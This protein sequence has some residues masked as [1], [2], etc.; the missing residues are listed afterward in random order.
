MVSTRAANLPP[1]YLGQAATRCFPALTN[2][3]SF[4]RGMGRSVHIARDRLVNPTVVYGNFYMT[5]ASEHAPLGTGTLKVAL[6]YP[7][8]TFTLANECVAAGNAAVAFPVGNTSLTFAVTV[9]KG[10]R[11]WL[12]SYQVN[13]AGILWTQVAGGN[14][15]YGAPADEGFEIGT[16]DNDKTVNGV[17]AY[18]NGIAFFPLVIATLK[19]TPGIL[20]LG[21]SREAGGVGGVI[22]AT[23]DVGPAARIVGP[24]AGYTQFAMSATLQSGWNAGSHAWLL[25]LV[26]A[27][28][29]THMLNCYGANDIGNGDSAATVVAARAGCAASAKGVKADLIVI[30]NT[31]YPYLASSD[32]FV[33]KVNQTAGSNQLRILAL[34]DAIRSGIAGE[35]AVWDEADGI[36]P[37]R[38]G[39][40]PVSR[41]PSLAA[42]TPASVTGA[43]SGTTLTVTMIAV[44]SLGAGDYL[45]DAGGNIA[46][47]TWIVEQLTGTTGGT[48]TYRVSKSHSGFPYHNTVT[49]TTIT[50]AGQVTRD[51]LHAQFA[52]EELIVRRVGAQLHQLLAN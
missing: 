29:W 8:G 35:D 12:R 46:D 40:Y 45:Y 39:K 41:D 42:R 22:D 1:Q 44:G 6:E 21:D 38:E 31:L 33:T 5:G 34:N 16:I 13:A 11:F 3:A 26:A 50:T 48:G 36:D 7:L 28:F 15:S 47:S 19:R 9:P 17:V 49:S 23:A 52:G 10:A 25:A 14:G 43:I 32:V 30:G 18:G 37:F 24:Q 51:G 20:I 4:T 27:G 2:N